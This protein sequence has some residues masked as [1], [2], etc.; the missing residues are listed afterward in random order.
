MPT[1]LTPVNDIGQPHGYWEMYFS[2]GPLRCKGGYLNGVKHGM[3]EYYFMDGNLYYKGAFDIGKRI[4]YWI[5]YKQ[6]LF[7]A[8]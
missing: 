7:Y 8:N 6:K 1:D 3:W 2:N 5:E 4:G